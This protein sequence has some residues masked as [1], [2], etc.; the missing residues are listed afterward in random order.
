MKLSQCCKFMIGVALLMIAGCQHIGP[1]TIVDDRIPYNDAIATSWK[2]QTLLNIVRLRYMDIPEFVDVPSIVSGYEHSRTASGGLGTE[3]FPRSSISNLLGADLGGSRSMVDRPT[4]SYTPQTGSEFTRNLTNPLPPISILNLIE[5]GYPADVVLDLAV[6]SI[7]GVRNRSYTGSL[8]PGDAEFP[9]VLELMKKA[10]TSGHVSL[11]VVEAEG[12]RNSDVVMTIRDREI[13][14]PLALELAELRDI[15]RLD[16]DQ[17]EFK[18]VFGMLPAKK[19]EIAFRTRSI[20]RILT[21][22]ALNVQVPESHL[23]DGRVP[24]LGITASA[25]QP[26]MTV[27][28]GCELP[29]EA[30]VA[31][32]YQGHYFWIDHRDL[33]AKRSMIYLKLL[34]ALADTEQKEAVPALTIRAN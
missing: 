7:N 19:D 28:S 16:R 33:A 6:E 25:V 14:A 8:Q 29:P 34:L 9:R 3:I 21:F 11:R 26:Q 5:S 2:Q 13:P 22:L 10:Q 12:H 4:I 23:A 18:I 15:L 31:V 30:Y 17:E 32:R 20:L 1:R 27:L 24:D